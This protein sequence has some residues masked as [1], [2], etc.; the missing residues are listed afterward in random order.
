MK[1]LSQFI[2][3]TSLLLSIHLSSQVSVRVNINTAPQWGPVGYTDVRYYYLPDVESYYDVQSARF[4]FLDGGVWIHS[5]FL[6]LQYRSYDLYSG[7]KVVMSDY[8]GNSPYS[9]FKEHR[10][11]YAKGYRGREQRN[12]GER[13]EHQQGRPSNKNSGQHNKQ[14]RQNNQGQDHPVRDSHGHG[15]QG[16][17]D[18]NGG[19]SHGRGR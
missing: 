9:H 16:G 10:V 8:R 18:R 19:K 5:E 4:I 17:Q 14:D 6:P 1:F 13:P 15:E 7:Y 11:K 3:S 12:I 2:L